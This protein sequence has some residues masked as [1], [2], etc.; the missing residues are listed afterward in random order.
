MTGYGENLPSKSPLAIVWNDPSFR[1][2]GLLR[3]FSS[4]KIKLSHTPPAPY[5]RTWSTIL[6]RTWP[7]WLSWWA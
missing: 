5:I 1:H 6:P 3:E 4:V 7:A 2:L